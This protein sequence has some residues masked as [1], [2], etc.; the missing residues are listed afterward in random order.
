VKIAVAAPD[1]PC[2]A[3]GDQQWLDLGQELSRGVNQTGD[4]LSREEARPLSQGFVVL[5]QVAR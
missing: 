5:P 3:A 4:P 1:M 2:T